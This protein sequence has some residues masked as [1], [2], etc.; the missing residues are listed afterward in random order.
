MPSVPK[1]ASPPME[2]KLVFGI[3]K[4]WYLL[5]DGLPKWQAKALDER[6]NKQLLR[7]ALLF[8]TYD[9]AAHVEIYLDGD[10]LNLCGLLARAWAEKYESRGNVRLTGVPEVLVVKRSAARK[11]CV[12][13][14]TLLNVATQLGVTVVEESPTAV[15]AASLVK[16]LE[17]EWGYAVR[18]LTKPIRFNEFNTAILSNHVS[19]NVAGLAFHSKTPKFYAELYAGARQS[20]NP[21]PGRLL[22][23][24]WTQ[25]AL[26]M[27]PTPRTSWLSTRYWAYFGEDPGPD[28]T[29]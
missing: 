29:V 10:D 2:Q 5:K 15:S 1:L 23:E 18:D 13:P 14:E 22:P 20:K 24:A 9:N 7:Y 25:S 26:D 28:W 19:L 8:N 3:L 11:A 17:R 12:D 27:L 6:D 21:H 4:H 16:L